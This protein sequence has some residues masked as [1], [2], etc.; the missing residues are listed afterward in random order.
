[1]VISETSVGHAN[2]IGAN[3]LIPMPAETFSQGSLF[4]LVTP[5]ERQFSKSQFV[6]SDLLPPSQGNLTWPP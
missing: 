1:M 2:L 5:R 6:V 4:T 3:G